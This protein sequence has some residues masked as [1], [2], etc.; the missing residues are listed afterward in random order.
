MLRQHKR[1]RLRLLRCVRD[2]VHTPRARGA[3]NKRILNDRNPNSYIL[4]ARVCVCV[5]VCVKYR[6]ARFLESRH[7]ELEKCSLARCCEWP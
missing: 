6:S 2:T 5:C 3:N 4:S 1:E 7:A